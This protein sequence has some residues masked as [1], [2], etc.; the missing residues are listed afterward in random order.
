MSPHSR[1]STRSTQSHRSTLLLSLAALC[2]CSGCIALSFGSKEV[3][4]VDVNLE[5]RVSSLEARVN[6]LE[7]G[8]AIIRHVPPALSPDRDLQ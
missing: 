2:G 7:S 4:E 1:R 5:E 3:H 8:G 6:A